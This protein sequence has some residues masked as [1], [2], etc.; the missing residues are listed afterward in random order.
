MPHSNYTKI[1]DLLGEMAAKDQPVEIS[2]LAEEIRE[3]ELESFAVWLPNPKAGGAPVKSYCSTKSIRRLIR[4]VSDVGLVEIGDGRV[5]SITSYGRNAL[6]DDNYSTTLATH[7]AMY[8]KSHVGVTFSEIKATIA[9]V[10]HPELPFFDTIYGRI[11]EQRELQI[12][13]GRFRMVLYLLERCGMLPTLIRK[14]YL[15]PDTEAW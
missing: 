6:M 3:K 1:H 11:T 15:T 7:L 2:Q 5:C 4:F 10:R 9:G 13:E 8:L 12:G 14:V